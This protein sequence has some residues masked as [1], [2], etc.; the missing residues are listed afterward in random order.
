M[1]RRQRQIVNT[2]TEGAQGNAAPAEA[3]E[4]GA[5]RQQMFQEVSGRATLAGFGSHTGTSSLLNRFT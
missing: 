4:G 1:H 2:Q 5:A 3:S